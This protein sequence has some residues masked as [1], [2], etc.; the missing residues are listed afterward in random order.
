[1]NRDIQHRQG[2]SIAR[3]FQELRVKRQEVLS[4]P[5]ERALDAIFDYVHADAL[6]HSFPEED[7]Y[8]LIHDIGAEDSIELLS[9]ASERQWEYILDIEAWHQDKITLPSMSKWLYLLLK[10]DPDRLVRWFLNQKTEFV[11]FFMFR[12]MEVVVR[13]HDQDPSDFGDGFSTLDDTFYVRTID[14]PDSDQVYAIEQRDEFL[15]E[16]LNRLAAYDPF[17]YQNVLLEFSTVIPGEAEEEAYRLRNE[18]LAEKG[19]VPFDEAV[20]IYQPLKPNSL[21]TGRKRLVSRDDDPQTRPP[22]PFHPVQMLD[23]EGL[24]T[25]SLKTI[26]MEDVMQQLQAEFA[27][28]CNQVIAADQKHIREREQLKTVVR[29]VCGYISIGLER[30]TEKT[31]GPHVI[32]RSAAMIQRFPLSRIFRVGYGLALELKWSAQ[33]WRKTSWFANAG[34]PLT[35]WGEYWLGVLGGLLIKKPFFFDNYKTGVIYREFAS[36]EDIRRTEDVLNEIIAF[37]DLLSLIAFPSKDIPK[38]AFFDCKKFVLTLWAKHHVGL[39]ETLSPI[40]LDVFR[41]FFEDLWRTQ[42]KRRQIIKPIVKD[43]FLNWLSEKTGLNSDEITEKSGRT[44]EN[45][46]KE[47]ESEYRDVSPAYLDPKH[48]HLFLLEK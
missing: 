41:P 13:A 3:R 31:H 10:A 22:V 35:F 33:K 34:L 39:P 7:F 8:F 2:F 17:T 38:N 28:L 44:L 20:G 9:M 19:F 24:F 21:K 4:L 36:L 47:V 25:L 27:A 30:L 48:I 15:A 42:G 6:V 18:R 14:F 16:F 32:N 46:F 5:A 12:N 23:K 29:K 1:M 26:E 11:E 43:A 37:D 45:L 40:G